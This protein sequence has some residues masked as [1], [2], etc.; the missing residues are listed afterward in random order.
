MTQPGGSLARPYP[1]DAVS[2]RFLALI[3]GARPLEPDGAVGKLGSERFAD[4]PEV[5][6]DQP[7]VLRRRRLAR[8]AFGDI[9]EAAEVLIGGPEFEAR[10]QVY[11]RT[12][13]LEQ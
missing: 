8:R 4:Q 2:N 13:G 12:D 11:E 7:G 10:P 1:R 6:L 5:L 3:T 9:T